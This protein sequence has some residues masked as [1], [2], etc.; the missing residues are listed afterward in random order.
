MNVFGLNEQLTTEEAKKLRK[1]DLK[2]LLTSYA[3]EADVFAEIIQN[4]VDAIQT[5]INA[6]VYEK[7]ETPC[8]KIFIGRRSGDTDYFAVNDNGI[9]MPADVL[10]KFTIPGFSHLKKM[11]KTVG[12][13]GVGASFFFASSERASVKSIDIKNEA[14]AFTV[15]GSYTWIMNETEA[16]PNVTN[17]EDFPEKLLENITETRGTTVCYYFHNGIKPKNLNNIVL[18]GDSSEN[19]LNNWVNFFCAKTAIGQINDISDKKIKVIFY[20]D[21]GVSIHQSEWTFGKY[22]KEDKKLGYPFPWRIF[23]VHQE[24]EIIDATPASQQYKHKNKH[25]A[26]H[27]VWD[28]DVLDLLGIDFNEDE[29]ELVNSHFDFVDVF[30]AYS[31]DILKEVH[32]RLGTKANQIRYGI[33]IVVDNVPQGRMLDFDLTSNT[34][35]NRQTHAVIAFKSLELDTGRKIPANEVITEVIRKIGVRLMS[36]MTEYRWALR[37]K[38][39]PE[40]SSNLE[41]W[42]N[43]VRARTTNSLVEKFFTSQGLFPPIYVDPGSEG[44]VIALFTALLCNNILKGYR[45]FSLSGYERYDGL[46]SIESNREELTDVDDSFSIRDHERINGGELQVLEFKHQFA[47]LIDDFE[48]RKKNPSEINIAVCWTLPTMNT[49]RGEI[50]YCYGDRKDHRPLYG[51]THIWT[52]E[53]ETSIIPIISLQHFIAEKLKISEIEPG[54]GAATYRTLLQKD[55]ESS[56]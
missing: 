23:K 7:N 6:S 50:T 47:S 52:D 12:Y 39:R 44:D 32:K 36:V 22:S 16:E 46:I 10:N 31:T 42:R 43:D 24:K 48:F 8:I 17:R 40:V 20:L 53:N 26:I 56:I 21:K 15:K 19:E 3:D 1:N 25:Q 41:E 2:N 35:L 55:V 4:A 33:R 18:V 9:G 45:L 11:G 54:L 28:K 14:A 30:F 29:S 49:N 34:G 13:K 27:A 37:K 38:D 5:A 51:V